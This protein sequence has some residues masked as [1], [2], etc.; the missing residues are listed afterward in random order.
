VIEPH[1]RALQPRPPKKQTLTPTLHP[2]NPNQTAWCA[3]PAFL[4]PR[5]LAGVRPL[6]AGWAR[7]LAAPQPGKLENAT[8]RVPTPLGDVQAVF[9]QGGGAVALS[10][11]V[12]PGGSAQVCLPPLHAAFGGAGSSDALTVD[13]VSVPTATWG[14]LLCAASDLPAGAHQVRRIARGGKP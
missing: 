10:L 3:S 6:A 5:F 4:I 7:F 14:R 9:S 2:L 1:L 13:G 8:M 12:P 11:T